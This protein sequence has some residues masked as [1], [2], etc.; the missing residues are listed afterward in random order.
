MVGIESEKNLGRMRMKRGKIRFR[1]RRGRE[2]NR[3]K[4]QNIVKTGTKTRWGENE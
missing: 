3:N 1:E 2:V 4:K